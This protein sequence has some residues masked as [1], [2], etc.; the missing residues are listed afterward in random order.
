L[1][2]REIQPEQ[3]AGDFSYHESSSLIN[4]QISDTW[5]IWYYAYYGL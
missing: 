4:V 5:I 2:H 1:N 3:P